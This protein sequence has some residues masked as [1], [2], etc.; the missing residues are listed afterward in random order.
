MASHW[1]PRQGL[2]SGSQMLGCLLPRKQPAYCSS[3]AGPHVTKLQRLRF[4]PE[5]EDHMPSVP[6]AA[7]SLPHT[8]AL[9]LG[10]RQRCCQH[11]CCW[12]S[13]TA[14]PALLLQ[15]CPWHSPWA[16]TAPDS[17]S[18]RL[19][20][21]PRTSKNETVTK[22]GLYAKTCSRIDV[23]SVSKYFLS[24]CSTPGTRLGSN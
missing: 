19:P 1:L 10:R 13:C 24:A 9:L 17:R 2:E 15:T 14:T 5:L 23:S 18:L 11:G 12:A 8:S 3:A 7:V 4:V 22:E 6:P 16:P 21:C 20:P